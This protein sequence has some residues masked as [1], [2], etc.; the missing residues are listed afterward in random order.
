MN[1]ISQA[2]SGS[3]FFDIINTCNEAV[4]NSDQRDR[5]DL[6]LCLKT[7]LSGLLFHLYY[8]IIYNIYVELYYSM[9]IL[10]FI[11]NWF[12]DNLDSY[13]IVN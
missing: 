10:V 5:I 3:T 13:A 2:A 9:I 11:I 8:P 7:E 1:E 12:Y 6:W 4:T